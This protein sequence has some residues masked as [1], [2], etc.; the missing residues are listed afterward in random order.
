MSLFNPQDEQLQFAA[1]LKRIRELRGFSQTSLAEEMTRR[2]GSDQKPIPRQNISA[3]EAGHIPNPSFLISL[4]DVLD[5]SVEYLIGN[6]NTVN[7]QLNISDLF[8]LPTN[9]EELDVLQ[10]ANDPLYYCPENGT[11]YWTLMDPVTRT[12]VSVEN[13]PLSIA[14]LKGTLYS[15]TEKPLGERLSISEAKKKEDI[16]VMP[17]GFPKAACEKLKGWYSYD[18]DNDLFVKNDKSFAFPPEQYGSAYIGYSD[19]PKGFQ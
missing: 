16:Y 1:R 13:P 6:T 3:W 18:A 10:F 11:G 12:L 17:L 8:Q 5:V 14:D 9:F 4:A 7:S 2:Q 19:L 15:I